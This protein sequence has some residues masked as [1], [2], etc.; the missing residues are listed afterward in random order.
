MKC[1]PY[2]ISLESFCVIQQS[3]Q[4]STERMASLYISVL[5]IGLVFQPIWCQQCDVVVISQAAI[6]EEIR[7]EMANV[8]NTVSF[9][10]NVSAYNAEQLAERLCDLIDVKLENVTEKI[11][12]KLENVTEKIKAKLTLAFASVF[13]LLL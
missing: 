9:D 8:L 7:D 6:K 10:G 12:A 2:K 1:L 13:S 5:L 11:E 4:K 3:L